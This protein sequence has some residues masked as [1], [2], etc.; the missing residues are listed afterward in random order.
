[1]SKLFQTT[2]IAALAALLATVPITGFAQDTAPDNGATSEVAEPDAVDTEPPLGGMEPAPDP[3]AAMDDSSGTDLTPDGVMGEKPETD[4]DMATEA[5][6]KPIE[7]QI[8]LQSEDTILAKNLLG[9][10]VYTTL[11]E[12][13]VGSISDLIINLDGTVEGVVIGVGG[14]L[15]IGKKLVAVK[16]DSLDVSTNATGSARLTSSATKADLEAAEPFVTAKEQQD[17][18]AAQQVPDATV[19]GEPV[20]A[21]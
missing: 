3:G 5:P 9:S 14:F 1:M 6:A 20:A 12:Q 8:I 4:S 21:E 19:G 2:C 11:G 7:G 18:E 15:G 10:T 13:T 16:M 17:A